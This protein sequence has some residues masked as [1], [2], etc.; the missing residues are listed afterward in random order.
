MNVEN[1]K[2]ELNE[3]DIQGVLDRRVHADKN[4]SDVKVSI[5]NG[6]VLLSAKY[7]VPI[8]GAVNLNVNL[9]PEMKDSRT[10]TIRMDFVNL[11]G[12]I[13]GMIMKF[14][15]SK[16]S[17]F[18]FVSREDNTLIVTLDELLEFY[19]IKGAVDVSKFA[20]VGNLLVIDAEGDVSLF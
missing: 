9:V 17:E 14:I 13:T 6:A 12:M 10:L 19:D 20:V 11:G 2:L 16:T 1:L 4:L 15:D 3:K 18:A 7:Q 8:M 5:K